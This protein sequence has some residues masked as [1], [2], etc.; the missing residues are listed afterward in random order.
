MSMKKAQQGFTLIELMI[1]VAII[2]ILAAIAIPAY[3]DYTT[4]AKVAEAGSLVD[5]LKTDLHDYLGDK[6][7]W[8]TDETVFQTFAGSKVLDGKY[9][10]SITIA[11]G[12][13]TATF[14]AAA[15]VAD[16]ETI[17]YEFTVIG[18]VPSMTCVGTGSTLPAKYMPKACK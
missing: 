11:G 16:T 5:G 8:P 9:V 7:A 18:G 4:R 3:N 1:V 12:T 2:G 14:N 13:V 17:I 15:G 10:T 6:G